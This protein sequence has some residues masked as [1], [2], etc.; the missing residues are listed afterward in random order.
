MSE[1]KRESW[2]SFQRKLERSAPD[3][4]TN[5]GSKFPHN[6]GNQTKL[7]YNQLRFCFFSIWLTGKSIRTAWS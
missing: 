6:Y 2:K 7:F 3:I 4:F 5:A 1:K